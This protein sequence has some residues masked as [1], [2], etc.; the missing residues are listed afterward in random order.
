[1]SYN[2]TLLV[3][4]EALHKQDT[5]E[6]TYGCRHTNPDICSNNS[7]PNVCAFTSDDCICKK[8]PRSWAK[9]FKELEKSNSKKE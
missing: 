2:K 4:K 5:I 1:M 8:P 3:A 6:K 7:L 9:L